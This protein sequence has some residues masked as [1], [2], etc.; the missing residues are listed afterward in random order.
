MTLKVTFGYLYLLCLTFDNFLS[1]VYSDCVSVLH[2][3]QN[4]MT[5]VS[6][7]SAIAAITFKV[8]QGYQ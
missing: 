1:V 5:F 8:T 4:F 3:I 7:T 6:L 2:C